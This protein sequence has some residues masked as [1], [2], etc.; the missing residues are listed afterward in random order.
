MTT[1]DFV[2]EQGERSQ[3]Q[4]T[5]QRRSERAQRHRLIVFAGLACVF[6]LL[7]LAPSMV[8]HSSI[9]RSYLIDYLGAQG[10]QADVASVRIGWL[11]P[12]RLK[13]VKI[14]GKAGSQIAIEQLDLSLT[15]GD[16]M[17]LPDDLGPIHLRGVA[18]AC[19][20]SDGKCSLENDFEAFLYSDYSD[21]PKSLTVANVQLH[22]VTISMTQSASD[23][24]WTL[25]QSNASI[26]LT[27]ASTELSVSGV[28]SEPN[29][30][31]G[32]LQSSLKL[33]ETEDDKTGNQ[34]SLNLSCESLPISISELLLTRFPDM[35]FGV[36]TRIH[37]D[38][39]GTIIA[40]GNSNGS[41][42]ASLQ[43][44][45]IRELTASE[46]GTRVWTNE[47]AI[48]NGKLILQGERLV[49]EAL[50]A[51]TD[52][53]SATID[54]AFSRSFSLTGSK[55][56]PLQWLEAID[57]NASA[58]V[59]IAALEQA[60]PGL[61]PLR[62]GVTL[63]SGRVI[64]HLASI[65]HG[66]RQQKKLHIDCDSFRAVSRGREFAI[67]P[68]T[69]IATVSSDDGQLMAEQFE[70]RS[71][72]GTAI[73][74]GNLESGSAD[75]NVDFGQLTNML[76]P[77]FKMTETRFA[78]NAR[79][80]VQWTSGDRDIWRLTGNGQTTNLLIQL[81][82]GRDIQRNAMRASIAAEGRWYKNTLRE[83]TRANLIIN[84][85]G[86]DLNAT[87]T[88]P[89]NHLSPD[90]QLP[91]TLKGE[92]RLD[93]MEGILDPWIP[94][95]VD[96]LA[97]NFS[98]EAKALVS[99]N[100]VMITNTALELTRPS[101]NYKQRQF[102][103]PLIKIQFDGNY[104]WPANSISARSI[105]IASDAF[106]LAGQGTMRTND[107]NME[108][109][110]RANLDRIQGYPDQ[111]LGASDT[112]QTVT[113]QASAVPPSDAWMVLGDCEGEIS[114]RSI[115]ND[116]F[117]EVSSV[118]QN[119]ACLQPATQH[120][121]VQTV[122][123]WRQQDAPQQPKATV[124]WSEPNLTLEARLRH[125]PDSDTITAEQ[126]QIAGDW[127]AAN[128]SGQARWTNGLSEMDLTGASRLKMN[129]V[130]Q[131]FSKM[132]DIDIRATGIHEAALNLRAAIIDG[133]D[134]EFTLATD[135]GWE[136]GHIA[137]M[138]IGQALVPLK[139]TETSLKVE[140]AEIP[141][142]RGNLAFA[143]QLHYR[144][145]PV[146]IHLEP[147]TTASAIQLTP[148]MTD[149]WLKYV[150]PLVANTT[151]IQ[152]TL[153]AKID[154]ATI[155]FDQPQQTQVIGRIN[156]S[157]AEMT[158]GPL[159]SQIIQ[160]IGNL[161][162]LTHGLSPQLSPQ[163]GPQRGPPPKITKLVTL[164]PQTVDFSVRQG[165]VSHQRLYLQLDRAQVITS[166]R[167]TLDGGL[168]MIA[169]IPL[170]TR[171]LGRDLQA[172]AGQVVTLPID[173][174]ISHPSLDS[175]SFRQIATQLGT[176]AVQ[177]TAENY[178]QQQLNKGLDKIFR[179]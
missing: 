81:P 144:P 178:L 176:Q 86:L 101:F 124:V 149:R 24:S 73:G 126:V 115:E 135:L 114:L 25:T 148:E 146:W 19:S 52:F 150:A 21:S 44:F 10:L 169:Q 152:G 38:A 28:L 85:L 40:D 123:P 179:W 27:E 174:S 22:D 54:G 56:N 2:L 13:N 159:A 108:L 99:L 48:L 119:I 120:A 110:Y 103:Q 100:Q 31:H 166:G 30:D 172:L 26:S 69:L 116:L 94:V 96:Q 57:G 78:G 55:D 157:E 74:N 117:I 41:V 39:T 109:K 141:V 111:Q 143:G 65:P 95:D 59:D 36:P 6:L 125:R 97:G 23:Q 75:F 17:S 145:G 4:Q 87:L 167:V 1:D 45:E 170:D 46:D 175:S 64:A 151:R 15:V 112:I 162:S 155:V 42:T 132:A 122:G 63:E 7:F 147:G 163:P 105:T 113:Y 58:E 32:S 165:I 29:G 177:N 37:G 156:I 50:S 128:L 104:N 118:G 49:G 76:L 90:S 138:N 3:R 5:D 89:I 131:H 161:T 68:I 88:E 16:L 92:G 77:I 98:T 173:G 60:L 34:W 129:E 9:G 43:N 82:G 142:N 11:T 47:R 70:W 134:V 35:A 84:S 66:S 53:A 67:D 107:I 133:G 121:S 140:Q 136:S 79:G 72:F 91:F 18:V 154:E 171:W 80:N 51:H 130:A 12:L 153:G 61:L 158:A 164:P 14:N 160:G 139:L 127:F 62:S 8:S 71:A 33:K 168:N 102:Q 106:S 137:G 83:L 93:T 20:M